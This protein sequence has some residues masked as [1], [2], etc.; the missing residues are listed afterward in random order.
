MKVWMVFDPQGD[1]HG[2]F[3][4]EKLADDCMAQMH[5]SGYGGFLGRAV[6]SSVL[7]Y[8]PRMAVLHTMAAEHSAGYLSTSPL[9][10]QVQ[11]DYAG[12]LPE[13]LKPI[14]KAE[15]NYWNPMYG[16]GVLVN[17][18]VSGYDEAAV[19]AEF[20]RLERQATDYLDR[21]SQE[22]AA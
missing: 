18:K 22:R 4:T 10:K 5:V 16:Q 1:L 14:T 19:K 20:D 3:E 8:L 17:V 12:N 13:V 11:S 9:D 6:V 21:R 15:I 7:S 2:V